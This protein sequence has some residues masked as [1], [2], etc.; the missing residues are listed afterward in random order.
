MKNNN[1]PIQALNP[2]PLPTQVRM[3]HFSST[4]H[5]SPL[6]VPLKFEQNDTENEMDDD[7]APCCQDGQILLNLLLVPEV[8]RDHALPLIRGYP[9]VLEIPTNRTRLRRR[10]RRKMAIMMMMMK[11]IIIKILMEKFDH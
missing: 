4:L 5:T 9:E 7:H 3:S 6:P 10:R 11:M 1:V 8:L 2:Q